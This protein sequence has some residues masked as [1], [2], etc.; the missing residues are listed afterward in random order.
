MNLDFTPNED[1]QLLLDSLQEL[2]DREAP[3]SYIAEC[4]RNHVRPDSFRKALHE[5]GFLSLGYPEEYGG[6]PVDTTTMMLVAEKI[7][8]HGL[9]MAWGLDIIEIRDILEFGTD[10]QKAEVLN[11]MSSGREPFALAITEPGAGSDNSGMTTTATT[12]DGKVT[13]NGTKTLVT[14]SLTCKYLLVLAVD[15]EADNPRKNVSMYLVPADTPGISQDK[16]TKVGWWTIDSAEIHFD[17]VV[18]DESTL[19]G[20]RGEGFIQL[21]KNFEI[22]R[23]AVCS[24]MLGL[25][26]AAFDDAAKYAGQRKAFGTNIGN[27]QLIQEKLTD[28]WISIENM[29]GLIYRSAAMI[30]AGEDVK[31]IT[32]ATKRYC[33]MEAFRVADEAMQI[34]GGMGYTDGARVAR[35]WRDLR[36]H[37]F[38]GGTDEIMVHIVGRQIVK[39]YQ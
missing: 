22:E 5:G 23:V 26:E 31:V 2:L 36:G 10:E 1:E 9:N 15:A 12:K 30:D 38:G 34:F 25:A 37:R 19:V 6:T 21:M 3:E 8:R 39:D 33:A 17:N 4:D 7:A 27:F 13:I 24:V 35:I 18:V 14:N 29:R 32:A 11:E 28:M 16:L 20:K